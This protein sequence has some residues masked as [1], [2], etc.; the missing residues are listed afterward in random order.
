MIEFFKT[1][2]G[3]THQVEAPEPGCWISVQSPT[4]DERTWMLEELGVVS[5][6]VSA[7]MDD[8]ERSRTDYDDDTGQALIIADCPF[9]ED[10]HEAEDA[11][12]T[13]YDTHPLTFLVLPEQDMLVTVSLRENRTV[14]VFKSGRKINTNQRTRLLLQMMMHL[15]HGYVTYLRNLERQF[16]ANERILRKSLRNKELIKMLGF[17]KSLVYFST[18]LKSTEATLARISAGRVIKLYEDDRDLLDDVLIEIRQAME[19]CTIHTRVLTG[20]MDTYGSV[21]SNNLNST[22][23]ILAIITLIIAIP[24][25]VFSF[26]GMN[27][28]LPTGIPF[29]DTWWVPLV[30]SIV[31]SLAMALWVRKSKLFK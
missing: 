31:G 5:E 26:Y 16:N 9:V 1:R 11:T 24:T 6:F 22:M 20:T 27:V 13:Q 19:M 7:A 23:Q 8:D 18:S 10:V 3:V 28:E 21:I 29:G 12:I 14:Q 15:S 25:V 4:P 17:E 30:I 2:D